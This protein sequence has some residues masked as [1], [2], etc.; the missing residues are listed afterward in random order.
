MRMSRDRRMF[1]RA[2]VLAGIGYTLVG[3]S[4]SG[5]NKHPE[6]DN[7]QSPDVRHSLEGL[8][9]YRKTDARYES[10]HG[11]FNQRIQKYPS[12]IVTCRSAD[13]VAKAVR[14]ARQEGMRAAVRSGGHS[15]EGFSSNDDGLVVDVSLMDSFEWLGEDG[16][17]I[18]VGPGLRLANLYGHLLPKNRIVPAGS[19]ASVGIAGLTLG[20]GYGLFSRSLG[21]T[22]DSLTSLTIVDGVGNVRSTDDDPELLWACKGGGNGNFGVVTS[23]TFKTHQAPKGLYSHRFK[24]YKLAPSRTASLLKNWFELATTL[25]QTSFSAFVLNGRTLTILVTDTE[26]EHSALKN[27]LNE[28]KTLMDKTTEGTHQELPAALSRY[29]GIRH[30]IL[31]KNASAGF[32]SGYSDIESV[33]PSIAETVAESRGTIFQVNTL[34]GAVTNGRFEKASAFV[35]RK[36]PFLAELQTYYD[37]PSQEESRLRGFRRIQALLRQAGVSR[38]YRNYPD[39]EFKNWANSYYGSNYSR[40]QAVKRRMDPEGLFTYSQGIQG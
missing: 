13:E 3:C 29:Y 38:H 36:Y 35:H 17:L 33:F 16:G 6:T 2:S 14:Y 30:P 18:R 4:D 28:L 39:I 22:C 40:L 7:L 37:R 23:L 11:G 12:V 9:A 1:L 27:V 34:G 15:F 24:A 32:Y 21:L 20:G 31:F 10:L 8:L 19:C 5:G 25:P 26:N